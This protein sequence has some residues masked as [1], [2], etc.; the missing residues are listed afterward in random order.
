MDY[1]VLSTLKH[2][3]G[4]TPLVIS[5]D[6]A[7]QWSIHLQDRVNKFP[8]H[9]QIELP[10]RVRDLRYA[11]PKYHFRAHREQGHN[12]YSLNLMHGVGRSCGEQIERNW[13]KH[14]ETAASTREMGPGS[15]HDTLEDHFAYANWRVFVS[16]GESPVF[17]F[18]SKS[19]SC[20]GDLLHRQHTEATRESG[21]QD[22]IFA[23]FSERL[24]DD[25]VSAWIEA[26]DAFD[27]DPALPD[28]YYRES[29]GL[30]EAD[31]RL[32]LAEEDDQAAED[33]T[34]SLHEVTPAALIV[35][36]LEI[37]DQQ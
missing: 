9:L 24:Q 32:Q 7:C 18:V 22:I 37:E 34:L 27:E 23:E 29:T 2:R 3:T 19:H 20:V 15:R 1:I 6:I 28:P 21:V 35:E 36:L 31:I 14:S 17:S 26:A 30:T 13:P 4:V 11:I 8:S 5:Y 33:G 16:L 25:N 12:Q 10:T